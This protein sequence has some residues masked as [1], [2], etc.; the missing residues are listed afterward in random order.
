MGFQMKLNKW[1]DEKYVNTAIMGFPSNNFEEKTL[2]KYDPEFYKS[3]VS[4]R[5]RKTDKNGLPMEP[6]VFL[7]RST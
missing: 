7:P 4:K 5:K 3:R 2:K 1:L 6:F